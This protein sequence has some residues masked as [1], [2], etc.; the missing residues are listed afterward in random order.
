VLHLTLGSVSSIPLPYA[1]TSIFLQLYLKPAVHVSISVS[2]CF[3][4]PSSS[5]AMWCPLLCLFGNIVIIASQ[6]VFKPVLFVFACLSQY[7]LLV[8][9]LRNTL[10]AI[11]QALEKKSHQTDNYV[12]S[13]PVLN[14]V[15]NVIFYLTPL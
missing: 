9:F 10:L 14:T 2:M 12:K 11:F 13:K 6:H 1:V 5:V 7:G 15:L 3:L 8:S 4:S